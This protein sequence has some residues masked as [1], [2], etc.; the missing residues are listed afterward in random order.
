MKKLKELFIKFEALP[1]KVSFGILV[2]V[3]VSINALVRG[4]S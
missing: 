2:I 3:I 4:L 1:P